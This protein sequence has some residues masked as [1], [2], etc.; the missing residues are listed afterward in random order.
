MKEIWINLKL[1]FKRYD[2]Y[3]FR[4]FFYIFPD[5]LIFIFY[6]KPFLKK[7]KNVLVC[8]RDPLGCDVALRA[9]WQRHADP[10]S[11]YV[12]RLIYIYIILFIVTINRFSAFP[13]WEGSCPYKPSGIINPTV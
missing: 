9:T 3:N 11:A 2:F 7:I 12:A 1:Y 8:A 4:D 13:I 5:F 10:R 6:L